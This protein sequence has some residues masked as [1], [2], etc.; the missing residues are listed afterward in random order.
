MKISRVVLMLLA[1]MF[2]LPVVNCGS[3]S[4][5]GGD[6]VRELRSSLIQE[7]AAVSPFLGPSPHHGPSVLRRRGNLPV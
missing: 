7:G 6:T 2:I 3:S 5:S 1:C 4:D